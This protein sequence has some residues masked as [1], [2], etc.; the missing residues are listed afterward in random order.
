[1]A[2]L[3]DLIPLGIELTDEDGLPSNAS[4]VVLTITLPDGSVLLPSIANPPAVTGS[5]SAD[6]VPAQEGRYTVRWV[7]T[8]PAAAFTDSFDVRDASKRSLISLAEAKTHLN[9]S[10]SRTNEDE[11]LRAM[12]EAVTAVVERHRGEVIARRTIVETDPTGTSNRIVLSA[13]PVISVTSIVDHSGNADL[14]ADWLLDGQNGTL[15]R[16]S[17][18]HRGWRTTGMTVTYVAGHVVVPAHYILAAKII[19]AHLWQTQ[20]IQN[21]GQQP[22]LGGQSRRDEQIVTPSGMGFAIPHRAIELLGARPS[23]VV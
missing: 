8:G 7:T 20:R 1:M 3:G 15:S 18:F 11:E 14:V 5:Y 12:I 10:L 21:I 2:D 22:T 17:S 6:Y 23:F 13:R 9:M 4:T 16:L 19:L